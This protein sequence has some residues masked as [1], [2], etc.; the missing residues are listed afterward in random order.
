MKAFCPAL[1]R[2][3][4]SLS[5]A[6][7][8]SLFLWS[9]FILLPHV[10]RLVS[11]LISFL[12]FY[13]TLLYSTLLYSTLLYSTLLYSTLLYSTLLY[14]NLFYSLAL[15]STSSAPLYL[16]QFSSIQVSSPLM[17]KIFFCYQDYSYKFYLHL[18]L[19]P[20]LFF[21]FYSLILLLM[22]LF[23]FFFLCCSCSFS[24]PLLFLLLPTLLLVLHFHLPS[25]SSSPSGYSGG[26]HG[27]QACISALQPAGSTLFS[28]HDTLINV[29]KTRKK[30]VGSI[31]NLMM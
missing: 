7:S 17:S 14:S 5:S 16:A 28:A 21:F 31:F 11:N 6:I 18:L 1:F 23:F 30:I 19:L 12:L 27:Q 8:L 22:L 25:L 26:G 13:S 9:Y 24:F 3:I 10:L 29:P 20:L 2:N 15:H 4:L